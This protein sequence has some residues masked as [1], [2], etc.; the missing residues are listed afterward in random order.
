MALE[1]VWPTLLCI[2]TKVTLSS[3]SSPPVSAWPPAPDLDDKEDTR[4]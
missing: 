3:R 4:Y 1:A 2:R